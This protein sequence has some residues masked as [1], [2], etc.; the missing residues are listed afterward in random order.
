LFPLRLASWDAVKAWEC[1]DADAGQD[2]A[3]E[4][5]EYHIPDFVNWTDPARYK[6][7]LARVLAGLR[8]A[9]EERTG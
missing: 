7:G 1:F 6:E 8:S 5:R 2:L 4:V 9:P 3:V